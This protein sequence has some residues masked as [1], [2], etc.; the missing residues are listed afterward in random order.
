MKR[1][2]LA[3]TVL[4]VLSVMPAKAEKVKIAEVIDSTVTLHVVSVSSFSATLM[5]SSARTMPKRAFVA[6]Q[7]LDTIH[8][9]WCDFT[10]AVTTSSGFIVPENGGIVSL[11]LAENSN[12][13]FGPDYKLHI[14]CLS[15]STSG[16]TNAALIQGY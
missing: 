1:L 6:I 11:P 5:E 7:N 14:W 10:V 15:A 13:L 8:K 3:V 2:I 4:M 16:S 9:L 12:G